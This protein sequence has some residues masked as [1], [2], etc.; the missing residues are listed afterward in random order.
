MLYQFK[1]EI[2]ITIPPWTEQAICHAIYYKA[3]LRMW[4]VAKKCAAR[5][6]NQPEGFRKGDLFECGQSVMRTGLLP[7]GQALT[8]LCVMFVWYVLQC[9]LKKKK[10]WEQVVRW[11]PEA[12]Q[13]WLAFE[14]S[15]VASPDTD[16]PL[17]YFLIARNVIEHPYRPSMIYMYCRDMLCDALS[18]L[19]LLGNL[20]YLMLCNAQKVCCGALSQ[21]C[22]G[23]TPPSVQPCL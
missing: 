2:P 21:K 10:K 3:E 16:T 9:E 8:T 17:I 15:G 12:D 6:G 19:T 22:P 18:I 11:S 1:T 20:F 5:V 7:R 14:Y 23:P 13:K 4:S